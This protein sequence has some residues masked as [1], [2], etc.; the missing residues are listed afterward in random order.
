MGGVEKEER[1]LGG[2]EKEERAFGGVEK[3]ERALRGGNEK[4]V[5]TFSKAW[6]IVANH[7]TFL[8]LPTNIFFF[9]ANKGNIGKYEA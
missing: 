6:S 1:A 5:E 3:E 7:S 2:V 8:Y 9:T 4:S